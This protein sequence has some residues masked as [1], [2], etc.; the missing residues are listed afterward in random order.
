MFPDGCDNSGHAIGNRSEAAIFEG[1]GIGCET[2]DLRSP[3]ICGESRGTNKGFGGDTTC[4]KAVTTQR[5]LFDERH[6]RAQ[7]R[8]T[9]GNNQSGRATTDDD[10]IVMM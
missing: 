8:S 7:L 4:V 2:K 3:R 9:T 5:S 6:T 1:D 10:E